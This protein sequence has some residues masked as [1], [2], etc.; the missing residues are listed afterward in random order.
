MR[1]I[2][3]LSEF[4]W[5]IGYIMKEE[6]DFLLPVKDIEDNLNIFNI[7]E[8]TIEIASE[9]FEVEITLTSIPLFMKFDLVSYVINAT[10]GEE[11]INNFL[12]NIYSTPFTSDSNVIT[13]IKSDFRVCMDLANL[14]CLLDNYEWPYLLLEHMYNN[15]Y[16]IAKSNYP[17][18][19]HELAFLLESLSAVVQKKLYND[20]NN[21]MNQELVK[22]TFSAMDNDE[23]K[24]E[25]TEVYKRLKAEHPEILKV[26]TQA[27]TLLKRLQFR[28]SV[29]I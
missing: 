8:K 2:S 9:H 27:V 15:T 5:L 19:I 14:G 6:A 13:E 1:K 17:V 18:I 12:K 28:N 29:L 23:T 21:F 26:Y 16:K 24:K 22:F 3:T 4:Q 11:G 10:Y 20:E 7:F 25:T